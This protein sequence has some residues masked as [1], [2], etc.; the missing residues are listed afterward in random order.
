LVRI[1]KYLAHYDKK[2]TNIIFSICERGKRIKVTSKVSIETK[3]WESK[4]QRVNPKYFNSVYV[5]KKLNKFQDFLES[6][7]AKHYEQYGSINFDKLKKS[8]N[9][10]HKHGKA[11]KFTFLKLIDEFIENSIKTSGIRDNTIRA[12]KGFRKNV[13]EFEEHRKKVITVNDINNDLMV[14]FKV[15]LQENYGY[16]D[17]TVHQRLKTKNLVL[18]YAFKKK[19]I[20][21]QDYKDVMVKKKK[22]TSVALT[23]SDVEK[24]IKYKP[25]RKKLIETR[26]YFLFQIYSGI[27]V[28]DLVSLTKGKIDLENGLINI[29]TKKTDS[30]ISIPI[31]KQLKA[32]LDEYDVTKFKKSIIA[33]YAGA[34]KDLCKEAGIDDIVVVTSYQN[35]K[36]I[37]EHKPKYELIA[38]HTARRTFVTRLRKRGISDSEIMQIT[39]HKSKASL[40][41]YTRIDNAEAVSNVKNILDE[42]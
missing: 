18:N 42:M 26:Y 3:Y 33:A 7:C 31:S 15:F 10:Y 14:S 32:I 17:S 27:R 40:E 34:I 9:D 8:V 19:Y 5:R 36:Q 6:E 21:N 38:S 11:K 25:K 41:N 16:K 30:V 2:H 24:L 23:D 20:D 39:G 37:E 29:V 4:K 12:Y 13:A 28:S 1:N 22:T 35:N